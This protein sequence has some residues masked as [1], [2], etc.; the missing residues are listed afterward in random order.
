MNDFE[1]RYWTRIAHRVV[2]L[3]ADTVTGVKLTSRKLHQVIG[4]L[5]FTQCTV[6][7]RLIHE[8]VDEGRLLW[9]GRLAPFLL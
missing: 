4:K 8:T 5:I 9:F 6:I 7:E 1:L 2:V 3:A